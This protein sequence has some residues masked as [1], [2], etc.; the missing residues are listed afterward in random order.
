M[1][2][3]TSCLCSTNCK[4]IMFLILIILESISRACSIVHH[5]AINWRV[6]HA[7]DPPTGK[8]RSLVHARSGKKTKENRTSLEWSLTGKGNFIVRLA[9]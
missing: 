8:A 7:S 3:Q 5:H 6:S 4:M 2:H 1:V 9:I